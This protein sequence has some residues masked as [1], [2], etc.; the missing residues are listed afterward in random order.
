MSD[1][2]KNLFEKFVNQNISPDELEQLLNWINRNEDFKD[3]EILEKIWIN[4]ENTEGIDKSKAQRIRAKLNSRIREERSKHTDKARRISPWWTRVAAGLILAVI[5]GLGLMY[6]LNSPVVVKSDFGEI[7]EVRLPDN[8]LVRL[9]ANSEISYSRRWQSQEVRTVSLEGEAY[10]EVSKDLKGHKKFVVHTK[11]LSV[12]VLGTEFNVN[13]RSSST[14]VF[15]E[16]GSV[17]L[18]TLNRN[19]SLMMVPGEEAGLDHKGLLTKSK[20]LIVL[21]PSD[22]K[23]GSMILKDVRLSAILKEYENVFGGKYSVSKKDLLDQTFT[24]VFPITDKRKA[25]SILHDLTGS[26]IELNDE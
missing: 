9:N 16:K 5:S 26:R 11:D 25:L 24:I 12:E 3:I 8:S 1:F 13:T 23:D 17:K 21:P 15:L 19:D 4:L 6:Y 10:F 22:W 2:Y 14:K 20:S 7:V 18:S